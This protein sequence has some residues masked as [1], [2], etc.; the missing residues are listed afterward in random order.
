MNVSARVVLFMSAA[1]L[2]GCS[3]GGGGGGSGIGSGGG[4]PPASGPTI[5]S[6]SPGA[7]T[8][9]AY[10]PTVYVTGTG[11]VAGSVVN[12]NGS[13]QPTQY[14]SSTFLQVTLPAANVSPGKSVSLTVSN[15][16]APTSNAVSLN[17]APANYSVR[18]IADG[19]PSDLAW[20]STNKVFYVIQTNGQLAVLDPV[21][22]SLRAVG[23]PGGAA[24]HLALSDDDTYLY[25]FQRG[26]T[27][28]VRLL[29]PALTTDVT[30][31][32][33]APAYDLKVAPGLA[34][35][36][37]VAFSQSATSLAIYDDATQRPTTFIS[38]P[39]YVLEITW[40]G[41]ASTLYGRSVQDSSN[42]FCKFGVAASGVVG[43]C[44][45]PYPTT[46]GAIGTGIYF[47]PSQGLIYLGTG[48]QWSQTL[49]PNALQWAGRFDAPG[50]AT[51]DPALGKVY[52]V[53]YTQ[54]ANA[55][56]ASYSLNTQAFIAAI[57]Y[58]EQGTGAAARAVRWGTDGLA[59]LSQTG[60]T[61]VNGSFVSASPVTP[62]P[63]P[64]N[65]S[66]VGG[67]QLL[68][69][70]QSAN[71]L[72]WSAS[73]QTLYL[74]VPGSDPVYGNSIVAMNPNSGAVV[75]SQRVLSDPQALAL[76]DDGTNLYT[77]LLGSG[78]IESVALPAL[79]P[80]L[81]IPLGWRA[82]SGGAR[83]A[84]DL[85]VAPGS[86]NTLAAA[87]GSTDPVSPGAGGELTIFDGATPRSNSA[88]PTIESFDS[89]QWGANASTV[90]S[91]DGEDTAL[92]L[93]TFNAD[94][95]GLSN[96][97]IYGGAFQT[98]FNRIHYD[99]ATGLIYGDD[100]SVVDPGTGI[101]VGSFPPSGRVAV[102]GALKK[103]WVIPNQPFGATLGDLVITACD[104]TTRS[105]VGTLTIPNVQGNVLRIIRWGTNGL[106]FATDLGFVYVVSGN[107]VQ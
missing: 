96:E 82:L 91:A 31:P 23:S 99:G 55:T 24:D 30:I 73:N 72:A 68:I 75:S 34:H 86:P 9:G 80:K 44:P 38:E 56:I 45:L 28:V 95:S 107:F 2:T 85:A 92:S 20:D 105:S 41:D 58:P 13:P 63:I 79:T 106:A 76:S 4:P 66:T 69:I 15:P 62:S 94:S 27:G 74:A 89:V 16:S 52:F 46:N 78:A 93:Y 49:D 98:F 84:L 10:D 47:D 87:I 81:Q 51:V 5:S 61:L 18:Q 54:P 104:L 103:A 21:S 7:V 97:K 64:A 26:G 65:Q 60:V 102:D 67:Q 57:S 36:F 6:L 53:F 32:L 40:A 3:G 90:I 77:G 17:I 83:V 22:G 70:P 33:Q 48:N 29:L 100:G 50:L 25:L 12:N 37:A 42:I 1:V 71:D 101:R 8:A 11:F 35:T 59:Y 43:S 88:I 19:T 39:P 14:L